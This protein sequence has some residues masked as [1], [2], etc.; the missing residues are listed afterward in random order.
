MM[1]LIAQTWLFLM[2]AA[3]IGIVV[4]HFLARDQKS[5]RQAQLEAEAVDARNRAIGI[6]KETEEYKLRLAELEG[7]PQ[8]ARAS[9]VA[10]RE[11]MSTRLSQLERELTTAQTAEKRL[12]EE[13]TRLK[14]EVDSFRVRYLEARAKWDEYQAKA[15]ALASAPQPVHLSAAQIVPDESMRRRVLELEGLLSEASREREKM[16]EHARSLGA[17]K[18]EL[19][20]QVVNAGQGSDKFADAAKQL[21]ARIS[22]LEGSLAIAARERDGA[23]QQTQGLTLRARELE[24]Q[25]AS[26]GQGNDKTLELA[27][28]MQARI[29]ELEVGHA[30]TS[31]ERDGA[32]SQAQTL[33][34]RL[35]DLERQLTSA[36]LVGERSAEAVR[37]QQARVT[38]LESRL[39]GGFAAAREADALRSRVADLQDK[40]GEA[41][42]AMS[43][44]ITTTRQETDP[45]RSRVAELEA[46]LAAVV[47]APATG[48]TLHVLATQSEAGLRAKLEVAEAKAGDAARLARRVTELEAAPRANA[49]G[50]ESKRLSAQVSKLEQELEVSRRQAQET[51]TL[52]T[53]I[54]NL[55][56]RLAEA[57]AAAERG[58]GLGGGDDV[59]LL[60]ARLADVEGR[61]MSSSQSSLESDKLRN[62]VVSLEALLHEASKSRDEAAVLRSKVAELDGRLGQ[63]MKAMAETRPRKPE[64]E[65]A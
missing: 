5:E 44:S 40:L 32:A 56:S 35:V 23:L 55:E 18:A 64:S 36:G 12:G 58:T 14:A 65:P 49:D 22:E 10:A 20:R 11:E 15:E 63:A 7:L 47:S 3:L 62:R 29:A 50:A 30:S 4:G 25:M 27:K 21:Q 41:E 17:R 54:I 1:Y 37:I 39:A 19:E 26:A 43:R 57:H 9:R 45:L 28:T 52:R 53:Q 24:R 46:R 16:S 59:A 51:Q 60:K 34:A 42:V 31:R 6:E 38:E 13:S 8:G 33:S 2:I 48:D 61:L